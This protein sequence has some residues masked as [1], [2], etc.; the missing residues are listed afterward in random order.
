MFQFLKQN[1]NRNGK[2]MKIRYYWK[3]EETGCE[4]VG[5]NKKKKTKFILMY[6]LHMYNLSKL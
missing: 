6:T 4:N 3:L 1:I 2:A 5:F